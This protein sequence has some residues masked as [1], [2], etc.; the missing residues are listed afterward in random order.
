[1]PRVP[2]LVTFIVAAAAAAA[3]GQ[4]P[5][6]GVTVFDGAR[7]IVGDAR[8]PIEN[9]SLVVSGARFAQVGR[10]ADVRA[11]AGATHVRLAGK[12]DDDSR[13]AVASSKV[14]H[15]I[16]TSRLSGSDSE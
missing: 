1:M 11:P 5:S 16:S 14:E 10:A 9:A 3:F 12:T 13:L 15:P 7:V 4:A 6:T 8:P 2:R